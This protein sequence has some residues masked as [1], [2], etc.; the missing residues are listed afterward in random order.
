MDPALVLIIKEAIAKILKDIIPDKDIK[1]SVNVDIS[2]VT[3]TKEK[4]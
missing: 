1:L 3:P 4:D 2:I